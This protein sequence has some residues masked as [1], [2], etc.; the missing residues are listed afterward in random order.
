MKFMTT[1]AAF[2]GATKECVEKFLAGEAAPQEG[3]KLLGRWHKADCSGG[4]SLY[5]TD[6]PVQM[7]KGAAQ[8]ADLMELTTVP[9]L[10]DAEAGPVLAALFGQ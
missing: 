10:E 6:N 3:V 1:W 8:W 2:P 5:E 7:Y 9:V 4:F